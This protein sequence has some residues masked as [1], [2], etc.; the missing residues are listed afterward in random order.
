MG[1]QKYNVLKTCYQVS[2]IALSQT[3]M[4]SIRASDATVTHLTK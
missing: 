4:M 3:I 2:N 1:L